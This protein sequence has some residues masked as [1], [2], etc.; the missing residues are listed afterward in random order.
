MHLK[1]FV[2]GNKV[3][4]HSSKWFNG[5]RMDI[6]NKEGEQTSLRCQNWW[7]ITLCINEHSNIKKI[8]TCVFSEENF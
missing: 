7:T 2:R 8:T 3:Y 1:L 5:L 4:F 6:Y